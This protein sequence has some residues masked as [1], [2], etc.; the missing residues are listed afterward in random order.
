MPV[1]IAGSPALPR[2]DVHTQRQLHN[3]IRAEGEGQC[4][5]GG[6]GVEEK[7]IYTPRSKRRSESQEKEANEDGAESPFSA[8]GATSNPSA[9]STSITSYLQQQVIIIS[10]MFRPQQRVTL[11]RTSWELHLGCD[12]S[13]VGD[14]HKPLP[15]END[16]QT[17]EQGHKASAAHSST[18]ALHDHA[19]AR[20]R[21]WVDKT[22]AKAANSTMCMHLSFFA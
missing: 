14:P 16:S 6:G 10:F 15:R 21:R 7:I 2:E 20:E 4:G 22:S 9:S 1:N 17:M 11:A 18:Q 8:R 5:V 19:D 12:R 3:P 13:K